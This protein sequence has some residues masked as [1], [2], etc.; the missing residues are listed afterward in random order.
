[1]SI[2]PVLL[3]L[4]P[5]S[6]TNSA[7]PAESV[8]KSTAV[9]ADKQVVNK[10]LSAV[11]LKDDATMRM[12]ADHEVLVEPS[13]ESR[14]GLR[15]TN[16]D[17]VLEATRRC[18]VGAVTHNYSLQPGYLVNWWCEYANRNGQV[19]PTSGHSI[20]VSVVGGK[21]RLRNFSYGSYGPIPTLVR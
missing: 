10:F 9:D 4:A 18:D 17:H 3:L 7:P 8:P 15:D 5:A 6:P 11:W 2:F 14:P 21:I 13:V 19:F 1:M 20:L 16:L 12:L